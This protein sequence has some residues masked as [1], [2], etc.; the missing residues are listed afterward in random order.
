MFKTPSLQR[1]WG[2]DYC[3]V[4][5]DK[6]GTRNMKTHINGAEMRGGLIFFS[7]SEEKAGEPLLDLLHSKSE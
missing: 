3:I 4:R 1:I 2:E 6:L 7:F 5:K